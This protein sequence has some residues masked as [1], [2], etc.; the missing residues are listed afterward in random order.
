MMN[1]ASNVPQTASSIQ[2]VAQSASLVT[3]IRQ[4]LMN[5]NAHASNII[6][7]YEDFESRLYCNPEQKTQASMPPSAN[8]VRGIG[9]EL[10]LLESMLIKINDMTKKLSQ[11][12]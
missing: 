11:I 7:E 12:A 2:G 5:L 9:S 8:G 6:K 4:R 3:E 10:D 1:I